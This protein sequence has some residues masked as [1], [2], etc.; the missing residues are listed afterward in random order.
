FTVDGRTH[1]IGPGDLFV[2]RPGVPHRI[3]SARPPG[4]GL[5]WIAFHT[6]LSSTVDKETRDG[7]LGTLFQ[8]FT[9]SGRALR[10]APGGRV[11]ALW[12]ASRLP[13]PGP[14]LPGGDHATRAVAQALLVALAQA[15]TDGLRPVPAIPDDPRPGLVR[16]ALRYIADN[17]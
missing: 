11:P 3:V 6:R 5:A 16:Q 10:D 1:P 17:L 12:R 14:A 13:G 9:V 15:G 2:A 8:G 7:E 4:I